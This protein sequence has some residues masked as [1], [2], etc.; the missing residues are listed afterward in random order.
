MADTTFVDGETVIETEWLQ[1]VNDFV[2][3]AGHYGTN[4]TRAETVNAVYEALLIKPFIQYALT[5]SNNI[6]EFVT[7]LGMSPSLL[8]RPHPGAGAM[9]VDIA[10]GRL[11]I[12][13]S[14]TLVETNEQTVNF[15]APT[16]NPRWD[17]IV[18]D[19]TTGTA[20][21]VAGTEDPSPS[22]PAIPAGKIPIASVYLEPSTTE[23]TDGNISEQRTMF[24]V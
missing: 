23:I 13:S 16:T 20:S 1:D 4:L 17:Y 3:G 19:D 22:L 2:Y 18:I 7:N 8:F 6:D 24:L 10:A 15:T 21:I 14:Q 5:N 12:K 11:Y 9:D